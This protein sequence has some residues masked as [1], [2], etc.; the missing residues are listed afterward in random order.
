MNTDEMMN[1]VTSLFQGLGDFFAQFV[2][3]IGD[4]FRQI[5][6]ALLL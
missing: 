4:F 3:F 6:A 1:W 5:L 2:T